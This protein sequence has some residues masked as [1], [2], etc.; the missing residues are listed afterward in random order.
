MQKLRE[1]D[2][3]KHSSTIQISNKISLLQRKA[4]NVLLANAYDDLPTKNR[5]QVSVIYLLEVLQIKTRN[6][7]YLK[8]IIKDLMSVVVEFNLLDKDDKNEWHA[9]TLLSYVV[10]KNG[11]CSYEYSS[12]LR[13]ILYSPAI[14]ARIKLSMQN[15]FSSKH[16]LALYELCIDY[17]IEKRGYGTTPFIE[18]EK[19]R[20]LMG[21][22][23][24]EYT[25]F[26]DLSKYI[27]KK[28]ILEINNKTD[29]FV[30][31]EYKK[32]VRKVVAIK[33]SIKP[34]PENKDKEISLLFQEI[35]K[36]ETNNMSP[37]SSKSELFERLQ[38]YFCLSPS[39]AQKV[40]G[41]YDKN[42]I[43]ENLT[44]IETKINRGE[45]QNIGA[46]TL[47]ALQEDYRN[48]KSQFDIEKEKR[49]K[50]N[51]KEEYQKEREEKQKAEHYRYQRIEAEKYKE[52]LSPQELQQIEVTI[53]KEVSK[54]IENQKSPDF[55]LPLLVR[56]E[57][58]KYLIEQSGALSFE[59]WQKKQK[60]QQ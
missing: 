40:L 52:S 44:Y 16:T 15:K 56:I 6:I 57:I 28:S 5:Y 10:I 2:V 34:N 54:E 27:I 1:K 46:Y 30:E 35:D 19:F 22:K 43:L 8:E 13:E 49:Q 51:Q 42:Y 48:Q 25:I 32:C 14:Y 60:V 59:Q 12:F 23:E 36:Q 26:K 3:I 45:I 21:F 58:E 7:K 29:I 39:Q 11:I 20:E 33:F 24:N 53:K 55:T 17:F 47:K 41:T 38:K 31:Q 9:T 4:W 18:I 37:I 50:Q